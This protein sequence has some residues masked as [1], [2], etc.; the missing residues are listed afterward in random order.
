M[1]AV[2]ANFV[3]SKRIMEGKGKP[4]SE[5]Q[6]EQIRNDKARI[7]LEREKLYSKGGYPGAY[8]SGN[9]RS[10]GARFQLTSNSTG[11]LNDPYSQALAE[12]RVAYNSGNPDEIKKVQI[13]YSGNP[14][15]AKAMDRFD[16]NYVKQNEREETS[17]QEQ[18]LLKQIVFDSVVDSENLTK[19]IKSPGFRN[20]VGFGIWPNSCTSG[21]NGVPYQC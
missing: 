17:R 4:M 8:P 1:T 21:A 12:I 6:K 9:P 7:L 5:F 13:N 20:A 11:E 18:H 3:D 14:E 19:I 16:K 15:L 10:S 2:Y